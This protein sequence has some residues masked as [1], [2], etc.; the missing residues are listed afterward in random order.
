MFKNP[1]SF[2]GRIRRT[3]YGISVIISSVSYGVVAAASLYGEGIGILQI[4]MLWFWWAQG[5]K[6]CHD[7]GNSGWWQLIPFYFFWLVFQEGEVE[8]NQYGENPKL[9]DANNSANLQEDKA[10]VQITNNNYAHP[11]N[12]KDVVKELERL[13]KLQQDG[14]ITF[15]ELEVLKKKVIDND[16]KKKIE[17]KE[18]ILASPPNIL[19]SVNDKTEN[20]PVNP[21]KE[22]PIILNVKV[23]EIKKKPMEEK[24][25]SQEKSEVNYYIPEKSNNK[26]ATYA[27]LF[28]LVLC[29]GVFVY[30]KYDES[31]IEASAKR[32]AK[33]HCDCEIKF[34]QDQSV[35]NAFFL[36]NIN[37]SNSKRLIDNYNEKIIIINDNHTKCLQSYDEE[38]KKQR[39]KIKDNY[40]KQKKFSELLRSESVNYVAKLSDL[41]S[42]NTKVNDIIVKYGAI[43]LD[44]NFFKEA[45][46]GREVPGFTF[47]Y[48][49]DFITIK[50]MGV[51]SI[52]DRSEYRLKVIVKNSSEDLPKLLNLIAVVKRN[53]SGWFIYDLK[54]ESITCSY[55]IYQSH[56]TEIYT[57]PNCNYSPDGA[58][59][60]WKLS[61]N[62]EEFEIYAGMYFNLPSN[63]KYF[64]KSIENPVDTII[65][66]YKPIN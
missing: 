17:E 39:E 13:M 48:V 7:V 53:E 10:I 35:A 58:K 43:N 23:E 52:S 5:A 11:K 12:S 56:F 15:E 30:V 22:I 55:L 44:T 60:I 24:I 66:K 4:P 1:F 33:L 57:I 47:N 36:N 45:L 27:M 37:E 38:I 14:I 65:I 42:S 54:E 9:K 29:L 41:E 64:V 28:L 49:S 46:I 51:N 40:E 32:I 8:Q 26:G 63:D 21:E 18:K 16:N 19:E 25:K 34:N 6:R 2:D 59:S 20:E 61:E 50:V 31:D 62:G 3:E